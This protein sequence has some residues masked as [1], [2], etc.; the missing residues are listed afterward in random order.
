MSQSRPIA[1]AI[2]S[3][4]YIENSLITF[5]LIN[6]LNHLLVVDIGSNFR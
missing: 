3:I 4:G 2:C 5:V 6:S 1:V